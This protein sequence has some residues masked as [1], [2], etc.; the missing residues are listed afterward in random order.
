MR[1]PDTQGAVLPFP[2]DRV[3]KR[4]RVQ[5]PPMKRL[6]MGAELRAFIEGMAKKEGIR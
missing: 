4:W 5:P 2:R 6:R 3:A 1:Q